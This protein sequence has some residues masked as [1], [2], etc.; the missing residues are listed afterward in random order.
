MH[1]L[2]RNSLPTPLQTIMIFFLFSYEQERKMFY[3]KIYRGRIL[4]MNYMYK[5]K[6]KHNKNEL[7]PRYI[8]HCFHST[9]IVKSMPNLILFV[10]LLLTLRC[11]YK[12]N[13]I[14]HVCRIFNF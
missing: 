4:E 5:K 7:K 10:W 11:I 12:H 2:F 8:L 3:Y 13:I 14:L 1:C 9:K 6:T